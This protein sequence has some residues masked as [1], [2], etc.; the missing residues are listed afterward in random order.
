MWISINPNIHVHALQ[1]MWTHFVSFACIFGVCHY[2]DKIHLLLGVTSDCMQHD[3]AS[4]DWGFT[5]YIHEYKTLLYILHIIHEYNNKPQYFIVLSQR[6]V[7]YSH[8]S[9]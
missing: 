8:W 4:Y 9:S 3:N 6:Q 1:I 5:N 2:I 7:Q